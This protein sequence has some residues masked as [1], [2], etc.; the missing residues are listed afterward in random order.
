MNFIS[1]YITFP[2]RKEA[3]SAMQILLED[4]LIACASLIDEA[5]SM[6]FWEGK[7]CKESETLVFAKT[8]KL[9]FPKV[10]KRIKE[11]HS[12]ICPCILALPIIDGNQEYFS[13]MQ[14]SLSRESS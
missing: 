1:V 9:L 10:E 4:K 5:S 12:Y 6:Y 7:M 8:S 2:N 3:E 14:D 11:L 13:W